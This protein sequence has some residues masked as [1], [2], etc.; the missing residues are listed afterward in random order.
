MSVSYCKNV[1]EKYIEIYY[2]WLLFVAISN[3]KYY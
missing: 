1:E 3:T 2:D